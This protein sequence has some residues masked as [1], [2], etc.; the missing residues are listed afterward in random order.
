MSDFSSA[1]INGKRYVFGLPGVYFDKLYNCSGGTF[2]VNNLWSY[3]R[4]EYHPRSMTLEIHCFIASLELSDLPRGP[5]WKSMVNKIFGDNFLGHS[6]NFASFY[7]PLTKIPLH[8][9]ILDIVS[10]YI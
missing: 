9:R 3:R 5:R 7:Q 6:S 4:R 2:T 8:D 10:T 1:E